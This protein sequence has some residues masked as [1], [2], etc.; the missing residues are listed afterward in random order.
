MVLSQPTKFGYDLVETN[1][2][3]LILKWVFESPVV[4][5]VI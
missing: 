2:V 1:W 4:V 5:V 3:V